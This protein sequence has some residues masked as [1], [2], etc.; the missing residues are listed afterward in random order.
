MVKE[1]E[2]R[3]ENIGALEGVVDVR[4]FPM[5]VFVVRVASSV[6]PRLLELL[7]DVLED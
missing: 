7:A 5:I 4:V 2:I 3:A 1:M 6:P